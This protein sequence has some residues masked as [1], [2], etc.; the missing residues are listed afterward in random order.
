MKI[1]LDHNLD[2]RLKNSFPT[3]EV[4]T[5]QSEGWAD[6][7][8]G[9]LLSLLEANG[10]DVMLTADSNMRSQQNFSSRRISVVVLRARNNRLATHLEMVDDIERAL[11]SIRKGEIV[12][13]FHS[14]FNR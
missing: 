4:S 9:A 2:R 7:L 13:I 5:T 1:L 11:I 3:H 10:F 14:D 12:E 8:N 6:V